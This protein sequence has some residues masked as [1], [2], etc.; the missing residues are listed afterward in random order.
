MKALRICVLGGTG[1]IGSHLVHRLTGL[2]LATTVVT[3][4]PERHRELLVDTTVKLVQANPYDSQAMRDLFQGCDAVIN[5]VGILN[6]SGSRRFQ[7]A[8]V[9]LPRSVVK[10]MREAGVTRLLHM[11]ALNAN[12]NEPNSRY[13]KTKG[14]GED[15]VHHAPGLAVTSFR[16]SVVFGPGDSFFNRFATLLRLSPP[17]FPLACAQA[18]F[19]PVYVGDVV[20][21]MVKALE[22]ESL[23]GRRLELCGPK[24][25]TLQKLVQYT[26]GQIGKNTLVVGLPDFASRLQ[27]HMLGLV[28][29]KPFTIDNY[30]SLQKDSVCSSPALPALGIRPRSV[31]AV[32]PTYLG[33]ARSRGQYTR[34]RA[35]ARREG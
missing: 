34:Y 6:E 15:L 21:A 16:P 3:R 1:F 4:R 35:T 32:V 7:T 18:R 8:H 33:D 20:E 27:A 22:D 11:S 13:L 2:G 19:A 14:E 12:V 10:A 23:A 28:P 31:E 5:L 30:H 17:L 24:V 9:E 29:G 26:A 25:Y